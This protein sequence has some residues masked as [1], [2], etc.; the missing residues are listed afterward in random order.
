MVE[1]ELR[2]FTRQGFCDN[3]SPQPRTGQDIGFVNGMDGERGIS[4]QCNLSCDP[5]NSLHLT[6]AIDHRVPGSVQ[7]WFHVLL[8][9]RSKIGSAN[10][11]ADY[12][13]VHSTSNFRTK[14]RVGKQGFGSKVS[15]ANVGV[16]PESFAEGQKSLFGPHF[17]VDA[18][19]GTSNRSCTIFSELELKDD[20]GAVHRTHKD[21]VCFLARFKS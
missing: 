1:L 6:D 2:I 13:H 3:L 21:G 10:Q 8:L 18:P 17:R 4:G 5:S 12:D 14:G 16:Q 9:P 15:W 7:V 20:E 11:F 19:L